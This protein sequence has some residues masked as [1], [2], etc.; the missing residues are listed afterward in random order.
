ME[1]SN[2]IRETVGRLSLLQWEVSSNGSRQCKQLHQS[3]FCLMKQYSILTITKKSEKN[4]QS[5]PMLLFTPDKWAADNVAYMDMFPNAGAACTPD[6]Q[7][8]RS[9]FLA[10]QCCWFFESIND[11]DWLV[12]S[13]TGIPVATY[14]HVVDCLGIGL[15]G[16]WNLWVQSPNA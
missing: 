6:H 11:A 10:A 7:V 5:F 9:V 8:G 16:F 3:W 14:S 12:T 13:W 2:S 1:Q 15:I 4:G